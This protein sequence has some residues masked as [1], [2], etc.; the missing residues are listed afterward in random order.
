MNF[1]PAFVDKE[2][3][4]LET[5]VDHIDHITEL[6][7]PDH[8]GLGSDFDGI[9]ST[10]TGLE[11]ATKMPNITR[12]LVKREYVDDDILKILGGNHLRVFKEIIP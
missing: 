7:G 2:N 3:A 1:A 12:E 9:G 5:L 11:D 10:P 4:T 6:V 8:V